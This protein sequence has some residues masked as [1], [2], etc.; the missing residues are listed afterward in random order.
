MK[1]AC[2]NCGNVYKWRKSLNKHWKEKHSGEKPDSSKFP[3]GMVSL[4]QSGNHTP[5]GQRRIYHNQLLKKITVASTDANPNGA[6]NDNSSMDS[7]NSSRATT[8]QNF[9][10]VS[11]NSG[12]RSSGAVEEQDHTSQSF[13]T[14]V[15]GPFITHSNQPVFPS[16]QLGNLTASLNGPIPSQTALNLSQRSSPMDETDSMDP[17][18]SG[19]QNEPLDFSVRR[20]EQPPA[21][22]AACTPVKM[23]TSWADGDDDVPSIDMTGLEDEEEAEGGALTETQGHKNN[24]LQCKKCSFIAK[25]L[26]DYSAHMT[27]HLNKKAFKCAACQKHF[28]QVNLLN[29]H[30]ASHHSDLITSHKVCPHADTIYCDCGKDPKRKIPKMDVVRRDYVGII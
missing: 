30:F 13:L 24:V 27:L 1:Y 23:E 2:S 3:A 6:G 4:V 22:D 21:S 9:L 25:T 28:E 14:N 11:Y 20:D 19:V 26:V 7:P 17:S 5:C 16:K 10:N 18:E 15:I 12:S 29:E 8:P